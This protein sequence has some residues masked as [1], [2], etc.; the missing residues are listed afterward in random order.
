MFRI[1]VSNCFNSFMTPANLSSVNILIFLLAFP[2]P[3]RGVRRSHKHIYRVWLMM[4]WERFNPSPGGFL[5]P[6]W[7]IFK[8]IVWLTSL[9]T[10][11]LSSH[12]WIQNGI[13][14]VFQCFADIYHIIAKIERS[15]FNY[16]VIALWGSIVCHVI[17]NRLCKYT[18]TDRQWWQTIIMSRLVGGGWRR[19]GVG[20]WVM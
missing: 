7:L 20:Y 1:T 2:W 16:C 13:L 3:D 14:Q 4:A 5:G 8:P 11:C 6:A 15:A 19:A 12:I 18:S 10:P 9:A 17:N